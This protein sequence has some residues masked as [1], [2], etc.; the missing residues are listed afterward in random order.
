MNRPIFCR[1]FRGAR[2]VELIG[3][4]EMERITVADWT[5]DYAE[6]SPVQSSSTQVQK[7][8]TLAL[9]QVAE[10]RKPGSD[11]DPS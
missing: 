3:A 6:K 8:R 1:D 5:R 7:E 11:S 9:N 10:T 2:R 4:T